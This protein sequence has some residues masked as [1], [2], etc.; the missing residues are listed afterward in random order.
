MTGRCL[1]V[2][3][4]SV[5]GEILLSSS[6]LAS[7]LVRHL[8]LEKLSKGTM[9][10]LRVLQPLSGESDNRLTLLGYN[11]V[12]IRQIPQGNVTVLQHTGLHDDFL[13][14]SGVLL[15]EPWIVSL[16]PRHHQIL[17]MAEQLMDRIC[18]QL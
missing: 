12:A 15:H 17:S 6:I 4:T 13:F 7:D 16:G 11:P 3:Q 5:E 1:E 10:I 8:S 2:Q 14:L 9:V 18:V